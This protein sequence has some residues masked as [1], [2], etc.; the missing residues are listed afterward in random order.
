[1]WWSDF[2]YMPWMFFGPLLM[3]TFVIILLSMMFFMM[4][5]GTMRGDRPRDALDILRERFARG[6]INQ[7]EYEERRRLLRT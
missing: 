6:E 4:R 1:M 7:D 5:G 2:W 3:I